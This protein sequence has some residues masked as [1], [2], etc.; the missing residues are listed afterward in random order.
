MASTFS[1]RPKGFSSKKIVQYLKLNNYANNGLNIIKLYAL[2][3]NKNKKITINEKEL[4]YKIFDRN[5]Q[6][7]ILANGENTGTYNSIKALIY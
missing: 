3:Y 1:S 4:N 2:S 7:P 5:K 6:I